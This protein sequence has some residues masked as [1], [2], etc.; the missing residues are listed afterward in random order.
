MQKNGE[1]RGKK[2]LTIPE[3]Q[4]NAQGYD[5]VKLQQTNSYNVLGITAW[6]TQASIIYWW[7]VARACSFVPMRKY[8]GCIVITSSQLVDAHDRVRASII[9]ECTHKLGTG[10]CCEIR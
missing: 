5:L 1:K 2:D 6:Y 7:Q 4:H 8:R 10:R 3:Q 9:D